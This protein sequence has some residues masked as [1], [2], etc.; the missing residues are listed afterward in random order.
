MGAA[1]RSSHQPRRAATQARNGPLV[2]AATANT[3]NATLMTEHTDDFEIINDL[4]DVTP[5][6]PTDRS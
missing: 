6:R 2:I 4:V 1:R 5:A 3:A